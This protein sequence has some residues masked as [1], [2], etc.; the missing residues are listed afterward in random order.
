MIVTSLEAFTCVATASG[1]PHTISFCEKLN[2]RSAPSA[3]ISL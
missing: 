2:V 1:A 3:A